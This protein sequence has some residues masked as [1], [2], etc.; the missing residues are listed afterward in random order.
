MHNSLLRFENVSDERNEPMNESCH[1]IFTHRKI[2]GKIKWDLLG[3]HHHQGLS[4]YKGC[5]HLNASQFKST[6]SRKKL[7]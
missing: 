1:L 2:D 4:I 5:D 6:C 3:K 7:N